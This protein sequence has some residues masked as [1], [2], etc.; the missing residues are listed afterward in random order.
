[1]QKFTW[2]RV[3]QC[4]FKSDSKSG[5]SEQHYADTRLILFDC[6]CTHV[7]KSKWHYLV[8]HGFKKYLGHCLEAHLSCILMYWLT[9]V[10]CPAASEA[11]YAVRVVKRYGFTSEN[12][13]T[14]L[15]K[16]L[17]PLCC[18]LHY[19]MASRTG[20]LPRMEESVSKYTEPQ[21]QVLSLNLSSCTE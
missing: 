6:T 5:V 20:M 7:V 14:F 17:L 21:L 9:Q 1:M 4:R 3:Q 19:Y 11:F 15:W 10:S 8:L 18:I 13:L 2:S 16:G 12:I